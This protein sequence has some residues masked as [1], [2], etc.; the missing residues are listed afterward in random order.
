MKIRA[1]L[2]AKMKGIIHIHIAQGGIRKVY[3]EQEVEGE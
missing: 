1:W 2:Q 3:F